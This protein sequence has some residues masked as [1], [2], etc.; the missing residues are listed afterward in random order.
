[1]KSVIL[2]LVPTHPHPRNTC[3]TFTLLQGQRTAARSLNAGQ[4][5]AAEAFFEFLFSDDKEFI[6]SGPGGVGKSYWLSA[7]IDQV[8]PRYHETCALM[9]IEPIYTQVEMTATTNKAAEVLAQATQRPVSTI[10]SFLGLK[11]KE[12]YDTGRSKITKIEGRWKVHENLV[13]AIDECSMIDSPLRQAIL[14]GTHNSKIIYIGDHCQLAPVM[15]P[16]SPIYRDS[17]P[18]YELT[19]PM[20]N[21]GQPALIALC[22]QLR[23]TVETGAFHPIHLVPGVIDHFDPDAAEALITASFIEPTREARILAYTNQRVTDFND[24]IRDFR[25]MPNEF[26]TGESLINNS[27]IEKGRDMLK[28]EQEVTIVSQGRDT[29]PIFIAPGVEL[30]VRYTTLETSTGGIFRD[31]PIPVDRNHH[32]ALIKHYAREKA[33]ATYFKL[34]QKFPDLRQPDAGTVHKA[35]GS[36]YDTVFI[37]LSNIS[38]C[39]NPDQAAR[40]LYVALTRA[41]NRVVMF[42]ELAPKYGGL[43]H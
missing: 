6:L 9:G 27:A 30:E 4:Q 40:M 26:T 1:M 37:D 2:F 33:W 14:E 5:A 18:F 34:K 42:G 32:Q 19:E 38:T 13:L 29:H 21:A 3:V 11:P 15:E 8:I 39:H 17:L 28:V 23:E 36:T 12:D 10:H 31:M 41:R 22:T 35:Q 20:R 25:G 24:H 16:L 43:V 7:V